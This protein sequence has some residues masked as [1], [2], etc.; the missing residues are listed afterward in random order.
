MIGLR[1]AVGWSDRSC[2]NREGMDR[3]EENRGAVK[4]H[5]ECEPLGDKEG[6]VRRTGG[7]CGV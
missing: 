3:S 7:D 6:G 5:A 4:S 2:P 1:I